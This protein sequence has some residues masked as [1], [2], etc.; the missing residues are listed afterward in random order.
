MCR[1]IK[2]TDGSGSPFYLNTDKIVT[3]HTVKN[4][5]VVKT[6]IFHEPY[7]RDN[8]LDW[9]NVKE[10]AEEVA[11]VCAGGFTLNLYTERPQNPEIVPR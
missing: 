9:L 10:T 4:S 5:D 3:V 6:T 8:A 7:N 1:L 11:K 2:L